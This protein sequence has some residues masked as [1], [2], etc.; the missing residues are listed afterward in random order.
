MYI[1]LYG[2]V[3][4][5]IV[6]QLER[7]TWTLSDVVE[8]SKT[9]SGFRFQMNLQVERLGIDNKKMVLVSE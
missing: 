9:L 3:P 6:K 5:S 4:Y 1:G 7:Q 2:I 8:A